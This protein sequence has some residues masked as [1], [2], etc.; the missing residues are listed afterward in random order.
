MN[1]ILPA[2]PKASYLAAQT[3]IDAAIKRVMSSGHYILVPELAA[4]EQEFS[5]AFGTVGTVGVG[6]GTD[7]I[8]LA[9]LAGGIGPGD[10]VVTVANTVTATVSA[11]MATGAKPLFAE[12]E[13]A[14]MLLDVGALDAT[15]AKLRDPRIKAVVPVHL[16]GQ[17]VDMPR[18]MEVAARHNLFVMEDCAQAHGAEIGGRKAGAWGA[19]ASFSFYPTKNIGAFGDAGAVTGRETALLEKVKLLRQYGWRKRYVSDLHGRN[20]RLDEIQAAILR[21]RLALLAGENQRRGEIAAQYLAGGRYYEHVPRIRAAYGARCDALGDALA[22]ILQDRV[23]YVKPEGGMFFWVRLT[24]EVD[25]NRLLPYAIEKEVVFVPGQGFYLD[26]ARH[27]DLHAMRLS[28]VTVDEARLALGIE[29]LAQ[30]L[31]AC[32]ARE[33]VAVSLA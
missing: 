22:G 16:Y 32:E 10:K 17:A 6:N 11:I 3:E 24:G 8:E 9:L 1:K 20:S 30:A 33:P 26:P 31:D 25:A 7:A 15:L 29:R 2:D 4:F 12:I 19:L 18:L 21:V 27:V 28:F 13:P 23:S 14:T 5:A